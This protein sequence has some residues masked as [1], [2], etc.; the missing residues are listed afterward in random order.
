[1]GIGLL[2]RKPLIKHVAR[3]K[4]LFIYNY[5]MP[6]DLIPKLGKGVLINREVFFESKDIGIGDY[7]YINGGHVY[8]SRIGKYCSI[9]FGVSIGPGEHHVHRITT[10]PISSRTFYRYDAGE[11][12]DK[13][14]TVVGND[15]WIG[16][17]A[18]ILQGIKIGDGA[19]IAAGAVV[20]KDVPP[21]AIMAGVPAKII[22]YR[23][24]E[25]IIEK[26]L[27]LE[28]WNKSVK[29]CENRLDAFHKDEFTVED[30]E[31]L[32]GDAEKDE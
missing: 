13:G 20:T 2:I 22:R 5:S 21:Y 30:A 27:K 4:G 8:R 18:T 16:N 3:K 26:L 28:W 14:L 6:F 11:F 24:D 23:F 10:F 17:H 19:V 29:W 15:V 1:M 7:T 12:V 9:G 32:L 25:K 31:T